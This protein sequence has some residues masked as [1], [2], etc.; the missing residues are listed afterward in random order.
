MYGLLPPEPGSLSGAWKIRYINIPLN[1]PDKL[2]AERGNGEAVFLKGFPVY[3]K[4]GR[5]GSIPHQ[6]PVLLQDEPVVLVSAYGFGIASADI[7]GYGRKVKPAINDDSDTL[8]VTYPTGDIPDTA[9][10]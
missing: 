3:D 10:E 1:T 6:I 8:R 9:L 2:L 4:G 7:P 5:I